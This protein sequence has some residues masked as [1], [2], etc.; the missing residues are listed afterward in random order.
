VRRA[1]GGS[2]RAEATPARRT[3]AL[4]ATAID[5]KF[6]F[7]A[8]LGVVSLKHNSIIKLFS[9][10]APF[11]RPTLAAS[12][13]RTHF[14]VIPERKWQC[15]TYVDPVRRRA[16]PFLFQVDELAMVQSAVGGF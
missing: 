4:H 9:V 7:D 2:L 6:V 14:A 3:L 10:A 11:V 12:M 13:A 16:F 8:V 5:S 1:Y 15:G